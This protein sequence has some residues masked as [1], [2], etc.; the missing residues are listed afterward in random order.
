MYGVLNG[1]VPSHTAEEALSNASPCR[2]TG[3]GR[4]FQQEALRRKVLVQRG[5]PAERATTL[6][7]QI[8]GGAA[9]YVAQ[10]DLATLRINN[11]QANT[12]RQQ[13]P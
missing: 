4:I 13:H 8:G 9:I 11:H 10:R 7:S 6:S 12:A 1:P 3:G 5:R 2:H